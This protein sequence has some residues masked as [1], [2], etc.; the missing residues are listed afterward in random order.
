MDWLFDWSHIKPSELVAFYHSYQNARVIV[1][2]GG[3]RKREILEE[4]VL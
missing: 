4:A 1:D 3:N 2:L